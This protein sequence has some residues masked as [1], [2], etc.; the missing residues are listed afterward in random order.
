MR[1]C[2]CAFFIVPNITL[3]GSELSGNI[4]M[5]G[6]I[7]ES[8][9]TIAT[10]NTWQEVSFGH[11]MPAKSAQDNKRIEKHFRI[12]L[13]HCALEH[14]Y[15]DKWLP[16][17]VIFDGVVKKS[18]DTLFLINDKNNDVALRIIDSNDNPAHS[19]KP[20]TSLMLDDAE[21]S[22]DFKVRLVPGKGKYRFNSAR[23]FVRF[24]VDY[25]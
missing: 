18:D 8:S 3:A 19:G 5:G 13:V 4:N 6:E 15:R 21:N 24:I 14:E 1:W 9:C 11:V 20:F 22:L 2:V 25:Q 12:R 16:A 17:S 23:F 10:E 7:V